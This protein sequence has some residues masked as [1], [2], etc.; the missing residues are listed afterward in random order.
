LAVR[1][2][3]V[4]CCWCHFCSLTPVLATGQR[5]NCQIILP[6]AAMLGAC[7]RRQAKHCQRVGKIFIA[8]FK[9]ADKKGGRPNPG[10]H[11]KQ[12]PN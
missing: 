10:D 11:L 8:C 9:L 2:H 7:L 3:G 4:R 5:K 1:A 12:T 6:V